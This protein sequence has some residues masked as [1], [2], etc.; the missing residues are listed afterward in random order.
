[1]D[2]RLSVFINCPFDEEYRPTL[3]LVPEEHAYN[4][5]ISDLAGYDFPPLRC[6]EEAVVQRVM[7]WLVNRVDAAEGLD[8]PAVLDALPR[9]RERLSQAKAAW[10]DVD[11]KQSY[12]LARQ[13]LPLPE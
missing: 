13:V 10:G 8:P 6:G 11:W 5:Y 4:R 7:S 12:Q 9:F 3:V 2:P 1:V